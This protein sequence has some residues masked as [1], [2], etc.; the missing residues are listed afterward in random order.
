MYITKPKSYFKLIE[1]AR[2]LFSTKWYET[3]S[4]AEICRNA[5]LSNGIFYRY[6]KNKKELFLKLLNEIVTYYEKSFSSITGGTFDERLDKFLNVV[7]STG[8]GDYKK[9]I[10]IYREGQYR[11]PKYEHHLR[12]LYAMGISNVFKRETTQAEQ[13]FVSGIVRFVTIR[14]IFNSLAYNKENLKKLIVEGIFEEDIK[15]FNS[16]FDNKNIVYP[17]FFDDDSTK[18]K[19]INSGIKLFGEKGFHKTDIHDISKNAGYSVGTFYLYFNSKETFLSEIV[20]LIGKRTRRFLSI[21]LNK[22]LNRA[23]NEI[24][25][26]YLFLKYFEENPEFYE[27]VRESEFVIRKTANEYYNAFERGYINN[28]KNI[29]LRDKKLVANSLMGISHYT[30]IEKIFLKRMDNEKTILKEISHYL[31]NGISI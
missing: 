17:E 20:E 12:D 16:I 9:D 13:L 3:V 5:G 18:S 23:E 1:S 25:G 24:R 21:N 29:K 2:N 10:L 7:V 19:L 27:I 31:N 22:D 28:L 26:I 30:G 6:F 14:Y 8:V 15:D 4:V 11:F